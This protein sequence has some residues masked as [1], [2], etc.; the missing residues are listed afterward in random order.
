MLKDP[1]VQALQ[2]SGKF[3]NKAK[4]MYPHQQERLQALFKLLNYWIIAGVFSNHFHRFVVTSNRKK[5]EIQ[6]IHLPP[7]KAQDII[8][9]AEPFSQARRKQLK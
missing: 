8:C 6:T 9:P 4:K 5:E 3:V 7:H 2:R 1:D